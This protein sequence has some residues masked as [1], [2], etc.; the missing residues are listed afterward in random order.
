MWP[1]HISRHLQGAGLRIPPRP[2]YGPATSAGVSREQGSE[3]HGLLYSPPAF[4]AAKNAF[5]LSSHFPSQCFPLSFQTC[6]RRA[7]AQSHSVKHLPDCLSR[8][9]SE[10]TREVKGSGGQ[11]ETPQS[12]W[13]SHVPAPGKRH[14][15]P[16]DDRISLEISEI[17]WL[18]SNGPILK[19]FCKSIKNMQ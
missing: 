7:Q 4:I 15:E 8:K 2:P 16:P 11:T 10:T 6:S 13:R 12:L 5:H 14:P 3:P 18:K 1:C 9:M 19:I 17:Q